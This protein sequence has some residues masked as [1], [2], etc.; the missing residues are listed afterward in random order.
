MGGDLV[1]A[2]TAL[3][4]EAAIG[5][6]LVA[7]SIS[8]VRQLLAAGLLDELRL[9]VHPVAARHGMRL[10][11]EGEPIYPLRLLRQRAPRASCDSSTPRGSEAFPTGVLRLVYS[12]AELPGTQA[13]DDVTDK[14]PGARPG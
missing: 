14:V 13:Y 5:K 6:I 1:E 9:L 3:K 12:P 11:D 2:V 7:G 10:F 4:S 8:V